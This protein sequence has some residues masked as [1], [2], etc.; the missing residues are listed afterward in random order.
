[1]T[2]QSFVQRGEDGGGIAE[3]DPAR[4]QWLERLDRSCD[5]SVIGV[6]GL[7]PNR[8]V[9]DIDLKHTFELNTVNDAGFSTC[10]ISVRC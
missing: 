5:S 3:I 2:L 1:M 4:R 10:A 6:R 8:L 7:G 9:R